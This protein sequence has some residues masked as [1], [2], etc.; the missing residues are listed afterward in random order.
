MKTLSGVD[1][2]F[3]HMET[4]ETPMHVGSLSLYDLPTGYRGDFYSDFRRHVR[5]RLH[6]VPV[7]TRRLA[8]M[9]LQFANP[10]WIEDGNIDLD[11]HVQQL[12]LPSPGTQAQLVEPEIKG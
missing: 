3:L 8:P 1:G 11:Y 5:Q 4:P 7:F 10:V 2:T 9:P 12:T 6:T